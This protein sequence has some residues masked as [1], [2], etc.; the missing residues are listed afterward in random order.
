LECGLEDFDRFHP[1]FSGLECLVIDKNLTLRLNFSKG[2]RGNGHQFVER[3]TGR[4]NPSV[5]P[6][7]RRWTTGQL[8]T[9]SLTPQFSPAIG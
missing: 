4:P 5:S 3:D 6:G 8:P 9:Q 2:S 1:A 7:S